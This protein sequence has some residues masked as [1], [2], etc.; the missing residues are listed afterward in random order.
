[1]KFKANVFVVSKYVKAGSDGKSYYNA[2]VIFDGEGRTRT[3]NVN[4]QVYDQ[5]IDK[6]DY[7]DV[8]FHSYDG[9]RKKDNQPFTTYTLDE[10]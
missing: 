9:V 6:A 4:A 5:L 7:E 10:I 8:S 1:M 2:N 3:I